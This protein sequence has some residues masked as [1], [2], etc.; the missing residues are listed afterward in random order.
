YHDLDHLVFDD[1]DDEGVR[2]EILAHIAREA[3]GQESADLRILCDIDDTI[4]C[5]LHDRRYPRGSVYPGAVAFLR[6]LDQGAAENPGRPGDLTF[7]TARP[8]DPRGL[9]E[10]YTRN[11][12][13]GLGL[14]PHS[15]MTGHILNLATK[16]RIAERK[17]INF[18]RSRLLFP[19]CQVV[20]I[21]DNGQADVEVGRAML[22]RDPDHVRAVFIHNVT[23][24][25]EDVR[26]ALADEGIFLFDTYVEA[27]ARAHELDLI[28]QES[29][30]RIRAAVSS[31][32]TGAVR[33]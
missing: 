13:A 10:S 32:A 11:G 26:S 5:M 21:G 27:A 18:D 6:A 1:I 12:L 30:E 20:F 16:G 2:E 7:I 23:G 24:A 3:E 15:V 4:L 8:S 28:S 17:M 31:G 22:A 29:L 14:P 19:E 9:V 33:A 25:G